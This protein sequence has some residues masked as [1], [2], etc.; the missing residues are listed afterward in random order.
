VAVRTSFGATI[1]AT[2]SATSGRMNRVDRLT[3]RSIEH[4][5]GWDAVVACF[6]DTS[7]GLPSTRNSGSLV[8]A[9]LASSR[10]T[11]ARTIDREQFR[12]RLKF[13][14]SHFKRMNSAETKTT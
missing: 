10:L 13:F 1:D 5:E 2:A 3:R 11:G 6:L 7:Q 8:A 12:L 9:T 4:L 14:D